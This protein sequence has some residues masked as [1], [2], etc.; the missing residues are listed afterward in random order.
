MASLRESTKKQYGQYLREYLEFFD[1]DGF[2][3]CPTNLLSFLTSLYERGVGYSAI[4]TARSAVSSVSAML[5]SEKIGDHPTVCRFM[6]GIFNLRPSLPRH[7]TTWNPDI[8]LTLLDKSSEHL[9]LLELSRKVVFLVTLLSAQRVSTISNIQLKDL[10]FTPTSLTV[11]IGMVKQSRP[12]KG[13]QPLLFETCSE[14]PN[15]CVVQQIKVYIKRTESLRELCS[16]L[17]IASTAP[18]KHATKIRWQT[19]LDLA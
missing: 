5:G 2:K 8:A 19:E 6:K 18:Y 15:L 12:G 4:N 11:N 9:P 7:A 16:Y 14:Y 10:K 1:T 17:F 13:Q 3:P